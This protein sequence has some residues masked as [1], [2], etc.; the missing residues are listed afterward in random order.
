MGAHGARDP[1][2]V[3]PR[4]E[5]IFFIFTSRKRFWRIVCICACTCVGSRAAGQ[6]GRWAGGQEG[7]RAGGRQLSSCGRSQPGVA[8]PGFCCAHLGRLR[9]LQ[10]CGGEQL[11]ERPTARVKGQARL[12]SRLGDGRHS[13]CG[14]A[15]GREKGKSALFRGQALGGQAVP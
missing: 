10:P 4:P 1:W 8:W 3:R 14:A 9:R 12:R 15:L 11:L 2:S 6:A 13:A 7:R 5:S